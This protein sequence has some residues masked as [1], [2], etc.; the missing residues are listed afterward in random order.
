MM[1]CHNKSRGAENK[2]GRYLWENFRMPTSMEAFIYLSQLLQAEA[3]DY[4]LIHWRRDW[5]GEG[6]E[7]NA[8]ALIWQLNDSNPTTSW[9]LVDFYFRPKPAWF[10]TTRA[11]APVTVGIARTPVWH[12]V[13]ENNRHETD[14]PTFQIWGSN[15]NIE[16]VKVE[17][18]LRMFDVAKGREVELREEV[19]KRI[20]TLEPSSS[21]ELGEIKCPETV[22]ESSY[23]VLAAT[24]HDPDTGAET[25]RKV[26]WPEPYRYLDLPADSGVEVQ[27]EGENVQLRCGSFPVKGLLAYVHHEDGEDADW[28]DNMWDMMPGERVKVAARGLNGRQVHLRHLAANP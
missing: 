3:L 21:T 20:V 12:F 1:D 28:A 22:E 24:L 10:T 5:K 17:L 15:L 13:D 16:E 9:A 7:L 11:F 8:G 18:R 26:S 23:I 25:C 19:R 27:V 2:M 6:H 14:V 4:A